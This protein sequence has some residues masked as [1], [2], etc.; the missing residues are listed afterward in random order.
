MFRRQRKIQAPFSLLIIKPTN[1]K[2]IESVDPFRPQLTNNSWVL[3]GN[4]EIDSA[5]T[6]ISWFSFSDL[7]SN[8]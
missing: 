4:P 3:V 7:R 1:L 2:N 6:I 8:E 5:F